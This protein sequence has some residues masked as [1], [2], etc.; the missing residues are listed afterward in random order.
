LVAAANV[1]AAGSTREVPT[2]G[3]VNNT[4]TCTL[5]TSREAFSISAF[6]P[7][8]PAAVAVAITSPTE[9]ATVSSTSFP[10]LATASVNP[11]TVTNVEFYVDSILVGNDTS[12]PF[13]LAVSGASVGGHTLE[14]VAWDNAGNSATSAVVNVTAANLPPSVAL[15]SP[16]NGSPVLVG[17]SVALAATA[18]DDASVTNVDFYVDGSRV[19]SDN[20]SPYNGSWSSATLGAHALT[21]V[22]WDNGGLSTT[23]A[24]VNITGYASFA[25]YEP[26][27]YSLGNL[28]NGA[29]STA[30]GFSGNWTCGAAGTV[31]AGLTYPDLPTTANAL[32]SGG[33]RQYVS[34]TAPLSSGTEY[35]SFLFKT[36]AGNP[37][38]NINGVYFANGGTGLWFGFG[39]APASPTQ[40]RMGLGSMN[41]VGTSALG[42]TSL[43]T[44]PN[45]QT[46]GT[47]NLIVLKIDFNTSGNNDTVTVYINP[48]A[49]TNVPGVAADQTLSTFDVGTITGIG[50][51]VQGATTLTVDEIRRGS[52]Y[53]DVVGYSAVPPTPTIPTTLALSIAT[54]KQVS[55]TAFSTNTYQPQK[56][57]DNSVWANVGS[58][59][60]GNAVT[61]LYE[62]APAPFYQVLEFI[63]GG[64]G[65]DVMVNGSFEIPAGNN[66]GAANW[67]GPANTPT[68]S[69]YVTNQ[70]DALLPTEGTSMLF[71]EGT[72][73]TGS[74][75]ECDF[76]AISGGL[77]YKVVFDAA[78]PVKLNGGNPQYRVQF[79]NAGNAWISDTGWGSL[80]SVGGAWT[81]ISNNY[82]APGNAASLQVQFLEAVGGGAHWVTVVDNV[83]VSALA[84][85][86]AT[87][88][89]TPTL[90]AGAGFTA[91]VQTNGVTATAATG[92]VTFR[93]NS[94]Q[95][96]ANGVATGSATS[97]TA[98]LNPP[99]TVTAIYSGDATY[100][101]STNTLTVNAVNT[102][103]TNITSSVSGNQLTLSWPPDYTG[104]TL[105]AQTNDLTIGIT[106]IWTDVVGSDQTNT[107]ILGIDPAN[108]SV[109]FRLVY[110]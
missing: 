4:W 24:V 51:N 110:P 40:G 49:G 68:A 58:L 44:S 15:T 70:Y 61:S 66:V 25:A 50:V 88:V 21:A 95:L 26:F 37:G 56:S 90:Q 55:W 69:Q 109:F 6:A 28:V 77:T 36:T 52:T 57:T 46:Y 94:V 76:V 78:N 3:T 20:S 27:N 86:G 33:S 82:A 64:P 96:S 100:I 92:T 19:G 99:Y 30:N 73:G 60:F 32:S 8:P 89:L 97:A 53:G 85:V 75:V 5:G 18:T 11:G 14:V 31:V 81:T 16:A 41:T 48:A 93:T 103:P 23:S 47:T 39:L 45:L 63:P 79:F 12:A 54:G 74:V 35:V 7:A 10:I 13:S 1:R 87:N 34:F 59:L 105:Q 102:T 71:M 80:L 108:P 84:T 106:D 62:T 67:N 91:T 98:L 22:A 9:A 101:G 42:A 65:P 17:A 38:A 107:M 2:A 104:W 29:A 72:N 83:R 43:S